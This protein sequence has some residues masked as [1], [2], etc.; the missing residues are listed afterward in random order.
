MG[1]QGRK[2]PLEPAGIFGM[3]RPGGERECAE[4]VL[5][6][7]SAGQENVFGGI[8]ALPPP[9]SAAAE[10][11]VASDSRLERVVC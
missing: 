5:T 4:N 7:R 10:Q 3:G 11:V 1:E 9:R 8:G 2:Q 6:Y